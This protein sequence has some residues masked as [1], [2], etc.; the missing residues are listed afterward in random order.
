M[1]KKDIEAMAPIFIPIILLILGYIVINKVL[2]G[3]SAVASGASEG[4][5]LSRSDEQ[6]KASRD[7]IIEITV[8]GK[9][10]LSGNE[11][12]NLANTLH[13]AFKGVG[14]DTD[15]SKAVFTKLQN[16]D[17]FNALIRAFGVRDGMN[18]FDYLR[19]EIP[20]SSYIRLSVDD[21]NKILKSKHI[22]KNLF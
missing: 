22:T 1:E 5:G 7:A 14:T 2:G 6:A 18:I 8:T 16:Q 4:L 3:V 15:T 12:M 13:N 10:T 17:D 11:V 9:Q 21:V 20:Q 19:D